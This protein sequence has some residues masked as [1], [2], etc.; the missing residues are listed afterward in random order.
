MTVGPDPERSALVLGGGGLAG[1]AWELGLLQ[2]LLDEDVPLDDADLVV[3]TSAGSMVGALLRFG[4]V[5]QAYRHQLEPPPSNYVEPPAIDPGAYEARYRAALG[6][7]PVDEQT[8]RAR[9]GAAA[10]A[11]TDGQ[12][13]DERVATFAETLPAEWPS[14][15]LAVT[16]VDA[17]DGA[18]R[19]FTAD[20]GVPLQR[21]VAASC[22]VPFVWSPVRVG[23]RTYVD[24]GVRS[25]TNADVA[26]DCGRVL[27][28]ACRDELPAPTGPSL[29]EA[30]A[31]MRAAGT[32]VEVVVADA[33]SQSA[34]GTNS[35]ALTTQ[36]PSAHAG[37]VQAG[38]VAERVREFWLTSGAT[39]RRT[40]PRR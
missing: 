11:M 15:P 1:I 17:A 27:V 30:V 29:T 8:A 22:S 4:M 40:P 14:E 9:I 33:E 39:I 26:A 18:F 2:G 16:A 31:A 21:A 36:A 12:S 5:E 37:R 19:T 23:E 38:V 20:D 24:G 32:V 35:L 7:L 28:I 3:G 10:A 25:V 13:D 6:T 34:F